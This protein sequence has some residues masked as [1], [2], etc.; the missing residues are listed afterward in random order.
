VK[1]LLEGELLGNV[2]L[3]SVFRYDYT[4]FKMRK[5]TTTLKGVVAKKRNIKKKAAC[6]TLHM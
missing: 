5:I 3:K 1:L 2:A 6:F 4:L